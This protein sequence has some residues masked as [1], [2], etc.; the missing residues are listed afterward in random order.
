MN[1]PPPVTTTRFP[2]SIGPRT[3]NPPLKVRLLRPCDP[4]D[5][6]IRRDDDHE[7]VGRE[8]VLCPGIP[9][10]RLPP[11]GGGSPQKTG[12]SPAPPRGGSRGAGR[13]ATPAT[14]TRSAGSASGPPPPRRG[15]RTRR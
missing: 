7:V 5:R 1:P 3:R 13:W 9:G 12:G 4:C 10:L 2:R 8:Y 6:A 11:G 15:R 14:S